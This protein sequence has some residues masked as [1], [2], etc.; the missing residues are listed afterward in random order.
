MKNNYLIL[1][2]GFKYIQGSKFLGTFC[3]GETNFFGFVE[4]RFTYR[5]NAA[6]YMLLNF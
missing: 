4:G 6:V 3:M 1:N 5:M 2:Y